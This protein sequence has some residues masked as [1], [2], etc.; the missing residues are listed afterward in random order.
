MMEVTVALSSYQ[1]LPSVLQKWQTTPKVLRKTCM[2]NAT[3][4][5]T[6]VNLIAV[7]NSLVLCLEL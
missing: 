1:Q 6:S 3:T 5:H 7:C 4:L 2:E